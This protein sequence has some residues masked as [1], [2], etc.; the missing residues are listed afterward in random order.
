M[1]SQFE[2]TQEVQ[3]K[4]AFPVLVNIR[5]VVV[6]PLPPTDWVSV[7]LKLK[8]EPW[9]RPK[10]RA[11]LRVGP[12]LGIMIQIGMELRPCAKLESSLS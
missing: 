6:A 11:W 7:K 3:I 5:F 2:F 1:F 9:H 4:Q 12:W 8:P 10:Q